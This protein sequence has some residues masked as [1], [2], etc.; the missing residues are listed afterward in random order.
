MGATVRMDKFDA[1]VTLGLG[2]AIDLEGDRD[3]AIFVLRP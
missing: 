1:T 2:L 3:N